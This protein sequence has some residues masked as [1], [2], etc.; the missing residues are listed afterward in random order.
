MNTSVELS[1]KIVK[2]CCILHNFVRTRDGY[3]FDHT[4]S[5]HGFETSNDTI[6]TQNRSGN[7][8]RD[9]FANYFSTEEGKVE[10]QDRMIH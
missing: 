6:D 8:I 5:I 2:A 1:I 3:K 9:M 4:L 10:W 7:S